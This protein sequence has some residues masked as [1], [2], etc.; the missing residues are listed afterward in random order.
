MRAQPF[1]TP[2]HRGQLP[3]GP[4]RH[5]FVD[6]PERPSG[7]N[8]LCGN[9]PSTIM[10]PSRSHP[11]AWTEIR[12]GA[13]AHA[14][15]DSAGPAPVKRFALGP[16]GRPAGDRA[17]PPALDRQSWVAAATANNNNPDAAL[18][19]GVPAQIRVPKVGVAIANV[20]Y[21]GGRVTAD[22]DTLVTASCVLADFLPRRRCARRRPQITDAE[23]VCLAVAQILLDCPSEQHSCAWR[24]SACRTSLPTCPSSPLHKRMRALAPQIVRLLNLIAFSS[25]SWCDK[26][27]LLGL[28][29]SAVRRLARDRQ[30]LDLRRPRRL[31]LLR[32]PQPSSPTTTDPHR[33]ESLI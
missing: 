1:I 23:L 32:Q 24:W 21:G 29:A 6:G 20:D 13:R 12:L 14:P 4:C 31:R 3:A 33:T 5:A 22:L 2:M 27:R 28:H 15:S 7:R 10:S 8:A 18:D 30:A 17:P 19:R 11:G 16:A 25:P 9:T 26:I